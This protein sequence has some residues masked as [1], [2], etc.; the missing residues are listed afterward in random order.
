LRSLSCH[1]VMDAPR[2]TGDALAVEKDHQKLQPNSF[3]LSVHRA[4]NAGTRKT[5][6]KL[7]LGSGTFLLI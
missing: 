6:H 3:S 5:H 1:G 2:S 7:H 4:D